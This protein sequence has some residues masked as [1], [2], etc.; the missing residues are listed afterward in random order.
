DIATVVL[1]L[2]GTPTN[3]FDMEQRL[4]GLSFTAGSGLLNV[5]SPPNGNIAP[6]GYYM[7]FVLNSAGV[8][9]VARFVRLVPAPPN[10]APVAPITAPAG[11]VPVNPGQSVSFSGDGTDSD[12]S[13]SAYSWTF[14]GGVPASSSLATPGGVSYSLPGSFSGSFPV[15][16][17]KGLASQPATRTVTVSNFTLSVT[18]ASQAVMAGQSAT[19]TATVTAVS[20]FTGT[21]AFTVTG[22]PAGA[23]GTFTP[24]SV[25]GSGST[26][27]LVTT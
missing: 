4:V 10:Q 21:V 22:L 11:N 25:T 18:P 9:S 19:Y 23:V 8:P 6:P 20:G 7:L 27:L 14:P 16:D 5:T 12:G 24:P 1:V 2:P 15:T 26:S 3:A 17:D 13:I